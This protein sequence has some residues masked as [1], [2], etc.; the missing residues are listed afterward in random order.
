MK[1]AYLGKWECT[2]VWRYGQT[3]LCCTGEDG[4][5]VVRLW[6]VSRIIIF[7]YVPSTRFKSL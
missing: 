1:V 5:V 6:R 2:D 3:Q 4:L 7:I